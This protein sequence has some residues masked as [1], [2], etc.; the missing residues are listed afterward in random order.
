[1]G[2]NRQTAN[3][4]PGRS[5]PLLPATGCSRFISVLPRFIA[6]SSK[7]DHSMTDIQP[8]DNTLAE[9]HADANQAPHDDPDD[10]F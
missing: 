10:G 3:D 1:M 9:P 2:A 8:Q 6:A 7:P 5:R 4:K